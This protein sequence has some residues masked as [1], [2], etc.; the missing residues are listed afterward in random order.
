LNELPVKLV[1]LSSDLRQTEHSARQSHF[2]NRSGYA[3]VKT[4]NAEPYA[5]IGSKK[6]LGRK[7]KL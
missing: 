2:T 3:E 1:S 5:H 6:R 4:F 7:R